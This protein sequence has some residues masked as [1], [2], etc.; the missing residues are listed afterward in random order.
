MPGYNRDH[1]TDTEPKRREC[2]LKNIGEIYRDLKDDNERCYD[3]CDGCCCNVEDGK[4][5]CNDAI[6]ADALEKQIPI[7]PDFEQNLDDYT[8]RFI[9]RCGKKIIV[10]HDS[11]VMDNHDAPNYCSNCGQALDWN[12]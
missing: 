3:D 9:C 6:V 5:T 4:C 11:G 2:G 1:L 10:R 8:S 12:D 7:K